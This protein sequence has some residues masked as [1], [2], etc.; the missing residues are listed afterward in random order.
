[1]LTS[2]QLNWIAGII[3]GE[4]YISY[5][6]SPVVKVTMTDKDIIEKLHFLLP[7][8]KF[9]SFNRLGRKTCFGWSATGKRAASIMMTIY[10]LMG[11]R[12]KQAIEESLTKWKNAPGRGSHWKNSGTNF[13][14]KMNATRNNQGNVGGVAS[15]PSNSGSSGST[16]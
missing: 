6:L 5:Q 7:S 1:M 12:R 14:E 15:K 11:E 10:I 4:G 16:K 9:Y 13:K 8:N 2:Q 3:E